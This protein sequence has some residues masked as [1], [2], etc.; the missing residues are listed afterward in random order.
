MLYDHDADIYYQN[1]FFPQQYIC[2]YIPLGLSANN[3]LV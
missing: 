2:R 3:H 1:M